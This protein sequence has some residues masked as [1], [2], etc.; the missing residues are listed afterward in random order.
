MIVLDTHAWVWATTDETKLSARARERMRAETTL[1]VPVICAWEVAMLVAKKRLTL[2]RDVAD[3]IREALAEP[4]VTLLPL[5]PEIAVTSATLR[6]HG[7]PSDRMIVATAI[8][9]AADLV[10][11]DRSL[12]RS[13]LVKTIW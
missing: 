3:W 11:K 1:G 13:R 2:D 12:R 6:I 9:H 8:A 5:T 7:D 10:T 4:K